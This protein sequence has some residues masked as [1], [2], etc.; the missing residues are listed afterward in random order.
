MTEK[1]EKLL[2]QYNKYK[3]GY[4]CPPKSSQF[5]KGQSGL[6][7]VILSDLRSNII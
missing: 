1:V 3:V 2:K 5:K 7:F 6:L 4:K